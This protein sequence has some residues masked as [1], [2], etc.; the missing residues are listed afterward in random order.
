M[1]WW[2]G[3]RHRLLTLLRPGRARREREEERAFHLALESESLRREGHVSREA[4]RIARQR[5][6]AGLT[7][8]PAGWTVATIWRDVRLAA[9]ALRRSPG[10]SVPA[11]LTL[12]GT[13]AVTT[14]TTSVLGALF[15]RALPFP[16]DA[17]L[18]V[19]RQTDAARP[20]GFHV[21]LPNFRDWTQRSRTTSAMAA[22]HEVTSGIAAAGAAARPASVATVTGDFFRVLAVAPAL[23]R[24]IVPADEA[25]TARV[26]VIS[27]RLWREMFG[28][29]VDV[30]GRIVRIDGVPVTIVGV[31]P[32]AFRYPATAEVW[33]SWP[34]AS[35]QYLPRNTI[36]EQ[37]IARLAP[38]R[39]VPD[40]QEELGAIAAALH[41]AYPDLRLN[42]ATGARVI[43]LRDQIL[44][45]ER[46]VWWLL[47]GA[48]LFAAIA[49]CLNLVCANLA[50]ASARRADVAIRA[51]LGASRGRLLQYWLVEALVLAVASTAAAALA[52]PWLL[53]WLWSR[54]DLARLQTVQPRVD[55]WTLAVVLAVAVGS[56]VVIAIGPAA[57]WLL[58]G[59][60]EWRAVP[61]RGGSRTGGLRSA[62]IALQIAVAM[63]LLVAAGTAGRAAVTILGQPRGFDE[64]GVVTAD[65]RLPPRPRAETGALLEAV[66][67]R[68]REMPGVRAVGT[69]NNLPLS[70]DPGRSPRV[71]SAVVAYGR[72]GRVADG[73]VGAGFHAVDGDYFGAMGIPLLRGRSFEI[74]DGA[75]SPRVAV[76]SE[77]MARRFWPDEDAIGQ[78]FEVLGADQRLAGTP[79]TVIGVVGDVRTTSLEQDSLPDYYVS[80]DQGISVIW[81]RYLVARVDG[82]A[83]R[84]VA[85]LQRAVREAAPDVAVSVAT[86]HAR[87]RSSLARRLF[88]GETLVALGVAALLLVLVGI[89]GVLGA[90]VSA[91]T[92][93]IG[94]RIALGATASRVRREVLRSVGGAVALGMT[95]G[96]A[97]SVA[98][99]RQLGAIAAGAG[100]LDVLTV[101]SAAAAIASVALLAAVVPVSRATGVDPNLALRA[102]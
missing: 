36:T 86:M 21:S 74:T 76:V 58:R 81:R 39:A 55:T 95:G 41:V 27:D 78:R 85:S 90:S 77:R 75:A 60:P 99:Q 33:Q 73:E 51:A 6:G 42:Q 68:I 93:E 1:S 38:G 88:A 34:A 10:F 43:A 3:V 19:I 89:Y 20:T 28:A 48:V 23:G 47:G 14:V 17:E 29:A 37:V 70:A 52:A 66:R 65:L 5:L 91:S 22:W 100:P 83:A 15:V 24:A 67:A 57:A 25:D 92:R 61:A 45:S 50:R 97:V 30:G 87:V 71:A 9:R 82:D 8:P 102:D 46:A 7:G 63:V 49:A 84:Y 2:H 26:A 12:V 40:A 13:L 11:G 4:S 94:L 32:P 80:F 62:L 44:G 53:Q 64:G 101:V 16:G 72:G 59:E 98:L 96:V 56:A 54:T 69:V 31:M 35:Q 79:L 18:V